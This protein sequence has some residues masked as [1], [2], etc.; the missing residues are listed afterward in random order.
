[1]ITMPKRQKRAQTAGNKNKIKKQKK[2]CLPTIRTGQ[3]LSNCSSAHTKPLI[4]INCI[5]W[6]AAVVV[7]YIP[8]ITHVHMSNILHILPIC[9][10]TRLKRSRTPLLFLGLLYPDTAV[11][12][13]GC[14]RRLTYKTEKTGA[15]DQYPVLGTL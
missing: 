10:I 1:M 2:E 5:V 8:C 7:L 3:R 14:R 6:T 15:V 4:T 11:L 13:S 12:R 9:T